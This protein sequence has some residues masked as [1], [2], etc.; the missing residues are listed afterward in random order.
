[1]SIVLF[2]RLTEV[3]YYLVSTLVILVVAITMYISYS[4]VS[5][6]S[7]F[8]KINST[9]DTELSLYHDLNDV[10]VESLGPPN[11]IFSGLS[12]DDAMAQYK[13]I[14]DKQ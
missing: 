6:L 2:N 4:T 10:V 11:D 9:W 1:M 5:Q 14:V 12:T 13:T 8:I 3:M 7:G